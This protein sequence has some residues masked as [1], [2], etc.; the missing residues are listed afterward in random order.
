VDAPVYERSRLGRDCVVHG[1]AVFTQLD[2]TTLLLEGQSAQV[3]RFG[4]L[5]VHDAQA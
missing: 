1:P 3:H 4:S 5:I 2:T